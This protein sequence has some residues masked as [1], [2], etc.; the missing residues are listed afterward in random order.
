MAETLAY[1]FACDELTILYPEVMNCLSVPY[2][3]VIYTKL[4][5]YRDNRDITDG[6]YV[7]GEPFVFVYPHIRDRL[8][9]VVHELAHYIMY[10]TKVD[11]GMDKCERE[12]IAR[13]VAGHSWIKS[14]RIL[15][16]CP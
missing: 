7:D 14:D 3:L 6:L 5:R 2:P 15:Y 4:T 8:R 13:K 16:G 12:K 10:E 9:V 1:E 11:K